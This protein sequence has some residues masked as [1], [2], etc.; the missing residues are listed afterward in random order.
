[1]GKTRSTVFI[2]VQVPGTGNA[3]EIRMRGKWAPEIQ[4][5]FTTSNQKDEYGEKR[6]RNCFEFLRTRFREQGG[7]YCG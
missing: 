6:W 4:N 1:V 2:S 3:C 7:V 5:A